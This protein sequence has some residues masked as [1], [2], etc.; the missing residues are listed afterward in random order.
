MDGRE[1]GSRFLPP[2]PSGSEP[3]LGNA[4]TRDLS[5][6]DETR[7]L[8]AEETRDLGP[9]ETRDLGAPGPQS[10]AHGG[11]AA[12]SGA[13]AGWSPPPPAAPQGQWQAQPQQPWTQSPASSQPDN[14]SAVA[15]FT[16]SLVG[17]GLLLISFGLSSIVSVVCS[18]LGIFY[19]KR[20]RDRVDRGETPKHRGLAQAGYVIGL[21]SLVLSVL[22]TLAYGALLVVFL[23]SDEFRREFEREFERELDQRRS[24][25][26]F[27]L[28]VV[29][30]VRGAASLF[31]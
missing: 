25:L 17:G 19:S 24:A 7:D 27:G 28:I 4:Q 8:G 1:E 9:D 22:A 23:S 10:P 2:Q 12:P 29:R 16:L 11:F 30:L 3:D 14:G 21:V 31:G 5:A 6:A 20:G 18:A 15:G 26:L 13:D